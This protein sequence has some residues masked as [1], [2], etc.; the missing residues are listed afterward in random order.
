MV[1]DDHVR[2]SHKRVLHS[3]MGST[4]A[5]T[6]TSH[7]QMEANDSCYCKVRQR[8][9]SPRTLGQARYETGTRA[10]ADALSHHEFMIDKSTQA[11]VRTWQARRKRSMY[12]PA[13]SPASDHRC[14]LQVV[15]VVAALATSQL[16]N[17]HR[18]AGSRCAPGRGFNDAHGG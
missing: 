9:E 6:Q 2:E 8:E 10:R 7:G 18:C 4:C 15:H 16:Q 11:G 12:Q 5:W 13:V 14:H 1:D 17:R 3:H